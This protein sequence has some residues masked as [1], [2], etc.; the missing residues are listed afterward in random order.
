M[1]QNHACV[2]FG[3]VCL[4]VLGS[5]RLNK[6]S[7]SHETVQYSPHICNKKLAD[8]VCGNRITDI[9]SCTFTQVIFVSHLL[10]SVF[11]LCVNRLQRCLNLYRT[12]F[13]QSSTNF[14][15][16]YCCTC[17][18]SMSFCSSNTNLTSHSSSLQETD[19]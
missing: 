12:A 9:A 14:N 10:F 13:Y 16:K 18:A 5:A 4:H 6:W 3:L 1:N 15:L 17:L 19:V 11:I 7:Q 8:A 2:W